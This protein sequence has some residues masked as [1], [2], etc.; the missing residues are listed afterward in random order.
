MQGVEVAGWKGGGHSLRPRGG[1]A[2]TKDVALRPLL[3]LGSWNGQRGSLVNQRQLPSNL[4]RWPCLRAAWA[5]H[6]KL[7]E[8]SSGGITLVY[9]PSSSSIPALGFTE[10]TLLGRINLAC[11]VSP[12]VLPRWGGRWIPFGTPQVLWSEILIEIGT[13]LCSISDLGWV[14]TTD[15]R[16]GLCPSWNLSTKLYLLIFPLFL[17]YELD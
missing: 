6:G 9:T 2:E 1:Q 7:P 13:T 4:R 3:L 11:S 12:W 16:W 5:A 10:L 8:G 14:V 15:S 17:V